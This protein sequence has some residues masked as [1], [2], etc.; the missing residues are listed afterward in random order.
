MEAYVENNNQEELIET[1]Q[2]LAQDNKSND[3]KEKDENKK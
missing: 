2:L 3:S 1:L